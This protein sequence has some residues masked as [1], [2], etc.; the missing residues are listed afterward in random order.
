MTLDERAEWAREQA[1]ARDREADERDHQADE[2]DRQSDESDRRDDDATVRSG[3]ARRTRASAVYRAADPLVFL[4]LAASSPAARGKRPA[5]S[6][7]RLN[8]A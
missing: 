8:H 1:K 6:R 3:C 2:R 5:V 4:V 7:S